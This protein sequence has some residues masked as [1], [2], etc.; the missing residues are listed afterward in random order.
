M[1]Y[2]NHN[3]RLYQKQKVTNTKSDNY[4]LLT[5]AARYSNKKIVEFLEKEVNFN[6][7]KTRGR[8]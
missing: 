7:N 2:L 8:R 5:F 4:N 3:F 6:I 1:K